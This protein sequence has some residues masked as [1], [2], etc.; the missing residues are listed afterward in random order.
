MRRLATSTACRGEVA[1]LRL[2]PDKAPPYTGHTQ[3][4]Q[5]FV[6]RQGCP[7][8]DL[9]FQDFESA[10]RAV[11]AFLHRRLGMGLWMITRTQDAD[12]IVL[13]TEDHGY[14]VGP[15]RVFRW[16]DTFCS[17][18]V[19][20]E[21][22]R[23]SPDSRREPAYAVAPIA[24]EVPIQSYVGMPLRRQDGSLFGTLCAIDPQVQPDSLRDAEELVE[25][26]AGLLSRILSTELQA[27]E[28]ARRADLLADQAQTDEL[29]GLPNRRAWNHFLA[30]E[31]ERC[32][33]YGDSAALVAID[34]NE[35]KRTNDT[36]GHAA[37]DAVIIR[38][39]EALRE[40]VREPDLVAR[41]GGDEFGVV[42]VNCNLAGAEA[43]AARIRQ[44]FARH[45]VRAALGIAAHDPAQGLAASWQLADERMYEDKRAR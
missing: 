44:A 4:A 9:L 13:Q 19:N 7:V 27:A 5:E 36:E 3:H 29:T 17:A 42:A 16:A 30:R 2:S 33:R 45:G 43:L 20:G 35:I 15:G 37:G 14:G 22:P 11:L 18:M 6:N 10:G 40:A 21:G 12:W 24:S 26:L 38:A 23:V 34:L 31:D 25:M 32:R 39:A 8:T 1:G 41:L 28:A